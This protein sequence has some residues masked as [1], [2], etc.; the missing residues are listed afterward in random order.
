[1]SFLPKELSTVHP[2]HLPTMG[3]TSSML[4]GRE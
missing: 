3:V 4:L 1:V 2:Y